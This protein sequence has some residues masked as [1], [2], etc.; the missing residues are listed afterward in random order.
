MEY[1]STFVPVLQWFSDQG[2]H[3]C[4]KVMQNLSTYLEV[5]HLFSTVYAPWSNGT[6]ESVCKEV[7]RVMHACFQLGNPHPGS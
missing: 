3:F 2:P 6:V 7:L 4:N 1:F 5:K